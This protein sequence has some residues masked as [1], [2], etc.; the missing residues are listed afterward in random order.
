MTIASPSNGLTPTNE[1]MIEWTYA[2]IYRGM[3][4]LR[5][6]ILQECIKETNKRLEARR[7]EAKPR[8]FDFLRDSYGT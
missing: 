2:E 6:D 1:Q 3:K 8:G 7:K 4:Q 5:D